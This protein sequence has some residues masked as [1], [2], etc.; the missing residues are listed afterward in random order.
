M[1]SA[2]DQVGVV[3]RDHDVSKLS[4]AELRKKLA[5]AGISCG[6]IT[7]STRELY[8]EKLLKSRGVTIESRDLPV[9]SNRQSQSCI[10]PDV[11]NS[12]DENESDVFYG[13][14]VPSGCDKPGD[15][16]Y[17]KREEVVVAARKIKGAR[18]KSF[19]SRSEAEDYTNSQN[20]T[21][22]DCD[23]LVVGEGKENNFSAPRTQELTRL[24]ESIE[25]GELG[26]FNETAW[27]NPRCLVSSGD[28]PVA[29]QIGCKWNTLHVAAKSNQVAIAQ[30]LTE[31]L[32]SDDFWKLL[33]PSD[34]EETREQRKKFVID[35][36]LNS[37]D[38]GVS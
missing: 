26:S 37:P 4:K 8:E 25:N 1:M 29:L 9:Q 34:T 38:S 14:F 6:P 11:G 21:P 18:F 24:R 2:S 27:S 5:D 17:A 3:D 12:L 15:L 13:L 19:P 33:Y 28:A 35:L 23:K 32:K 30:S 36:Y 10:I 22:T 20:G 16:I 31:I 7:C